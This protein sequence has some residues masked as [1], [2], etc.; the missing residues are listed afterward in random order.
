M[1][2]GGDWS[3]EPLSVKFLELAR[4][5]QLGKRFI[6]QRFELP[7]VLHSIHS[8]SC[9]T[10]CFRQAL[11]LWSLLVG[12]MAPVVRQYGFCVRTAR[13]LLFISGR[14]PPQG[15]NRNHRV[16]TAASGQFVSDGFVD[17][18]TRLARMCLA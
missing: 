10:D 8:S 7:I 6:N 17:L 11:M 1:P 16:E 9:A 18:P 15:P 4:A 2:L 13:P 5:H 12:L 3:L 14:C